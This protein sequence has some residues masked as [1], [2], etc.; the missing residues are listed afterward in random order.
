MQS[1]AATLFDEGISTFSNIASRDAFLDR[2]KGDNFDGV[3]ELNEG[4]H[5]AMLFICP[6]RQKK[7]LAVSCLRQP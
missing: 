1:V 6:E 2:M 4:R 7:V 3:I 5:V